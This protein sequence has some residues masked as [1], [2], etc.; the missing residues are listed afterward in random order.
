MK[1]IPGVTPGII[2]WILRMAVFIRKEHV[3]EN[4]PSY[5]EYR[6]PVE[7]NEAQRQTIRDLNIA[8][9]TAAA[10][11]R[12]GKMGLMSQWLYA[13]CGALDY[14]ED[15][16]IADADGDHSFSIAGCTRVGVLLPKNEAILNLIKA[17]LALGRGVGVY[18]AQ[19][20][21]RDWMPRFQKILS[22]EGIY[23]EILRANT[24]RKA[25]REA[26]F[27]GL[28]ERCKAKRQSVVLLANGNL[29]KEGLD[30]VECPTLIETGIDFRL[31]NVLQRDQR[32]HRIN[33]EKDCKVYFFYYE[34]T[35]QETALSLVAA[36]ARAAKKVDGK[37]IEGLAQMGAEEDLMSVLLKAAEEEEQE[38]DFTAVNWGGLEVEDVLAR[39]EPQGHYVPFQDHIEKTDKEIVHGPQ[40]STR[41]Q[42]VDAGEMVQ[43][44]LF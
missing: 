37:L 6:V 17:E 23:S 40:P 9:G 39:P 22:Q 35:F 15:D 13:A 14:G 42:P 36:K 16:V 24:C 19:V 31:I 27:Q 8:H 21:R 28:V 30:L 11:C 7:P 25:D 34:G 26:W 5:T 10:L 41:R 18:F 20:N 1:E 12:S 32:A 29:V 44:T 38:Q 33:Q 4:L 3:S 2:S 43:L